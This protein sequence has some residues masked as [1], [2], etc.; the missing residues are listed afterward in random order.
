M[1][2]DMKDESLTGHKQ[3]P[4]K[5][6][7]KV[8]KAICKIII[9]NEGGKS[10]YATGFFIRI[11][12]ALKGLI[13]N[14]HVLNP[15]VIHLKIVVEIHDQKN[16][17]LNI[18]NRYVKYLEKPK[19]ITFIE[20]KDND[21]IYK[22]I[23][24]LNYDNNYIHNGYIIYK[25][26]DVF[27]IQHP[28]GKDAAC[29]SG[30][31]IYID[32]FEFLHK[33]STQY[34]SSGSP[35]ILLNNNINIILV[36]GI[37]KKGGK[38]NNCGTFIGELIREI[39]EELNKKLTIDLEEGINITCS[40]Y[41]NNKTKCTENKSK[42]EIKD[43]VIKKDKRNYFN[44][45][46]NK[47]IYR[48]KQAFT[49]NLVETN[50]IT[51]EC[52]SLVNINPANFNKSK[53]FFISEKFDNIQ[54]LTFINL[55]Q[56]NKVNS[57]N[58]NYKFKYFIDLPNTN[59]CL[60]V[61]NRNISKLNNQN[62]IIKNEI[63]YNRNSLAKIDLFNSN[64]QK[65]TDEDGELKSWENLLKIDLTF[66]SKVI[67]M[68][69]IFTECPGIKSLD[70]S[71]FLSD[72]NANVK[73]WIPINNEEKHQIVGDRYLKS[74]KDL[75]NFYNEDNSSL[76]YPTHCKIKNINLSNNIF[77]R[78]RRYKIDNTKYEHSSLKN[79]FLY[80][81]FFNYIGD[82]I[83]KL[84]DYQRLMNLI[85]NFEK[86]N[87]YNNMIRI[88]S[89]NSFLKN[90]NIYDKDKETINDMIKIFDEYTNLTTLNK[91][92][93]KYDIKKT[94]IM[95]DIFS[96]I[97]PLEEKHIPPDKNKFNLMEE[98]YGGYSSREIF[99]PK[100]KKIYFQYFLI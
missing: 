3:M 44:L 9:I 73:N 47:K 6:T 69:S 86:K 33:I 59:R 49:N 14:Y 22:E 38:K 89:I 81:F 57:I 91:S 30:K 97:F 25:D 88:Y 70:L 29:A 15:N 84:P 80:K 99:I 74:K 66:P 65:D 58:L 56:L 67:G 61:S 77:H 19:D 4:L 55:N 16:M 53:Y 64:T 17:I 41:E 46:I 8:K 62:S 39:N 87:I 26:V 95:V 54:A 35:I 36:I 13:T 94:L 18:T 51:S 34:G 21:Y 31:I 92:K 5:S 52:Q 42:E 28:L 78:K 60:P 23:E 50:F 12:N 75:F 48:I 90:R 7:D 43:L 76:I 1:E 40:K 63:F 24:F 96:S 83:D 37:H 100:K 2:N 93:Y 20:I 82:K 32:G 68:D 45:F 85:L 27:S 72:T 11:S 10:L 71:E 79:K 98:K